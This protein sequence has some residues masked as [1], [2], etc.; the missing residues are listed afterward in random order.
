MKKFYK[1]SNRFSFGGDHIIKATSNERDLFGL[2]EKSETYLKFT[3]EEIVQ[4]KL[5]LQKMG[6]KDGAP[7]VCMLNRDQRYL[8]DNFPEMKLDYH[9]FR[10]FSIKNY[11]LAAEELTKRGFYVIRMGVIVDELMDTDNP[12]IIEYADRGFR[13]DLLDLYLSA[14]CYLFLSCNTGADALPMVFHRPQVFVNISDFER[15]RSWC[16]NCLIIFKKYWLKKEKRFMTI[17]ETL[18][19]GAG[20][21]NRTEE[22]ENMGIELIENTREETLDV[23]DEMDQ[24]LKGTWQ[25]TQK[26]EDLQAR[27]WSYFKPNN[28]HYVIRSRIGAKFLRQHKEWLGLSDRA[29]K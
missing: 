14:N 8:C 3:E 28:L 13:T 22:Y 27:F 23:V 20:A 10:N 29:T 26:D 4:A 21:L 16:S 24:R 9:S 25:T 6:I 17:A 15:M 19:S 2:I 18:R 12:K 7:Y 1:L 5:G 11:M